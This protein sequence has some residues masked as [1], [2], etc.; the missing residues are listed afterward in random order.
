MKNE[1]SGSPCRFTGIMG[2]VPAIQEA[3]PMTEPDSRKYNPFMLNDS[4]W[5]HLAEMVWD[6]RRPRLP[7]HRGIRTLFINTIR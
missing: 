6:T 1:I 2:Q 7:K 5:R 3:S 4:A